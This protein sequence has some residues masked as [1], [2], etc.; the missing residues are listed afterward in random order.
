MYIG[1]Y[2]L[3]TSE[4]DVTVWPM[5]VHACNAERH[6][7]PAPN[8]DAW[9]H[10]HI[11]ELEGWK[12]LGIAALPPDVFK[13]S[14]G[15]P[16]VDEP[17]PPGIVL[18]AVGAKGEPLVNHS[19]RYGFRGVIVP[20]MRKLCILLN[21]HKGGRIP[22]REKELATLLIK[23]CFPEFTDEEVA[24]ALAHRPNTN[25]CR[26]ATVLTEENVEAAENIL[27]DDEELHEEVEK[28][29]KEAAAAKPG[30]SSSHQ[31]YVPA[32]GP[33]PAAPEPDAPTPWPPGDHGLAAAR[34]FLPLAPGC[35]LNIHKGKSW[36]VKYLYKPDPPRSYSE[37]WRDD[38]DGHSRFDVLRRCVTWAWHWH[39]KATGEVSIH[40]LATDFDAEAREK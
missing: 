11:D 38:E 35:S 19:A 12:V 39:N 7:I 26:H 24:A 32:G 40:E 18:A 34:A 20:L 25:K 37:A 23:F 14:V 31:P 17:V 13:E 4:F 10:I 9:K 1:G 22:T 33:A 6:F 28:S 27:E 2:V 30:A 3:G 16:C 5:V 8:G 29:K 36:Q 15:E 21:A